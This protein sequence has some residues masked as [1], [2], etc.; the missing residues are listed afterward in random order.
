MWVLG[1]PA[2]SLL[3]GEM[4]IAWKKGLRSSVGLLHLFCWWRHASAAVA[5][6][7]VAAQAHQHLGRSRSSAAPAATAAFAGNAGSTAAVKLRLGGTCSSGSGSSTTTIGSIWRKPYFGASLQQ[8]QQQHQCGQQRANQKVLGRGRHG[9]DG[10][11]GRGQC[12][13]GVAGLT[14]YV[15]NN[16]KGAVAMEDLRKVR[17]A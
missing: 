7:V 13:M 12:L 8:Q 11:R 3:G 5:G 1:S 4:S 16:L 14:S 9:G 15:N 2:A 10:S 17:S 6:G